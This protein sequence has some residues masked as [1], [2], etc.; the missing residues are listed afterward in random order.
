MR[1]NWVKQKPLHVANH[2]MVIVGFQSKPKQRKIFAISLAIS[3]LQNPP[4]RVNDF[5]NL[6][7][8]L[9]VLGTQSNK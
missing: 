2:Q 8:N 6:N 3:K 5:G 1:A 4:K 7:I 9:Q